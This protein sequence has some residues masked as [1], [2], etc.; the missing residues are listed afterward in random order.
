MPASVPPLSL[1]PLLNT[2]FTPGH[3]LE[4]VQK[5]KD[6][7]Q[8]DITLAASR[9]KQSKKLNFIFPTLIWQSSYPLA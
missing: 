9:K 2:A 7:Q 3:C 4:Y 1:M 8:R 5:I 6:P